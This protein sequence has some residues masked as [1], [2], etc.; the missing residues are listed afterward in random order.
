MNIGII[1]TG[2]I[3]APLGRLWAAAGHQVIFG[4]RDP[5]KLGD[6]LAKA[7]SN[8]KAGTPAEAAAFGD[9]VLEAIPFAKTPDLPADE[10]A[11]K[12]LLSASNYYP[13]RDGTI[14]LGGLTHTGWV[15]SHLPGT[16]VVKA[17]NM[18]RADVM[19]RYADGGEPDGYAILLAGDDAEAK[20]VAARLVRDA[21]FEPVDVGALDD[22]RV[23]ESPDAPLYDSQL[24][25]DEARRRLA[26]LKGGAA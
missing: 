14:D 8:A 17:F 19:E 23:F 1:G 22:A 20:D 12:V 9:V 13:Q 4:S 21:R 10:L 18:M 24:S 16:R 6:L 15:A 26:D 25:P 11:G 5:A 3:G 2:N 7:G